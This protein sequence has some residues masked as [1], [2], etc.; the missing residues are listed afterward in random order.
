[1]SKYM[2]FNWRFSALTLLDPNIGLIQEKKDLALSDLERGPYTMEKMKEA[3]LKL[4]AAALYCDDR[5][6]GS[7]ALPQVKHLLEF[8]LDH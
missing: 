1:M 4:F 3:D 7:G 8:T 2:I 5:Y 6:N